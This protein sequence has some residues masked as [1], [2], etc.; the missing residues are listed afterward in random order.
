MYH[1]DT[2]YFMLK[3]V[4]EFP[5]KEEVNSSIANKRRSMEIERNK[6]MRSSVGGYPQG[7]YMVDENG[8]YTNDFNRCVRLVK[9]TRGHRSKCIKKYC[10]KLF[11]RNKTFNMVVTN[12]RSYNRKATEFWHEYI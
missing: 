10:N 8:D 9:M 12:V 7:A 4:R 1:S 5:R 3:E 6:L 2:A 11:R